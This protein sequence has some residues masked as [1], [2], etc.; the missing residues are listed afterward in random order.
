MTLNHQKLERKFSECQNVPDYIV[1]GVNT[2]LQYGNKS[3]IFLCENLR[4]YPSFSKHFGSRFLFLKFVY[5]GC[6]PEGKG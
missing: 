6:S 1:Q 4:K 2:K 5:V 3:V